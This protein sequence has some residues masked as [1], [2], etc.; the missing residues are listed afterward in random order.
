MYDVFEETENGRFY[1]SENKLIGARLVG[2]RVS[3]DGYT[4]FEFKKGKKRY[5]VWID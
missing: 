2:I 3:A 4:I 1:E 5:E